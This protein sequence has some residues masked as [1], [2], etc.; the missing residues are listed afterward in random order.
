MQCVTVLLQ[1]CHIHT[2]VTWELF[3]VGEQGLCDYAYLRYVIS[4]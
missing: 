4:P 2:S 3:G 1:D